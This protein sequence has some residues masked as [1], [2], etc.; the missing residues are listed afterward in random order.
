MKYRNIAHAN[1]AK[2]D[3]MSKMGFWGGGGAVLDVV[4]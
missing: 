2:T 3:V 1:M 4:W